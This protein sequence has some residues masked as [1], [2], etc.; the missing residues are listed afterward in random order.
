MIILLYFKNEENIRSKMK[1]LECQQDYSSVFP[2]PQG[3]ITPQPVVESGQ[4]QNPCYLQM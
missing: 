2:D 4:I 3:Q 1:A